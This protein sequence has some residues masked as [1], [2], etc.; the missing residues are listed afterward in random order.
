M[1]LTDK[2]A[3]K[4]KDLLG[5]HLCLDFVNTVNWRGRDRSEDIFVTYN[6]FLDWSRYVKV[7]TADEY[8]IL[9]KK[10][11]RHAPEAKMALEKV[12]E[13]REIIFS[14]FSA[15]AAGR[16]PKGEDLS[17]FNSYLSKAMSHAQIHSSPNGFFW[18]T[19]GD[20]ETLDWML[21]PIVR[22]AA[23]L[24]VSSEVRKVKICGDYEC[25]WFFL[26]SS[27]NQSR[28]WCD[29]KDCGNR[30]KARRF[31]YKKKKESQ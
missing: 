7:V 23:D 25:G 1:V 22:S 12:V 30:A 19:A 11:K 6:D 20:K 5:E 4:F 16:T 21:D 17:I 8:D 14:I 3:A 31:Y 27:R 18:E 10:S 26:D 29:M 15:H 2:D 9:S 13:L 28:R 24:L